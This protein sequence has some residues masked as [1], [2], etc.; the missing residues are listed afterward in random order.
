M[1]FETEENFFFKCLIYF[2][3]WQSVYLSWKN[4]TVHFS[5]YDFSDCCKEQNHL[6]ISHLL[7]STAI[8]KAVLHSV[9]SVD[10]HL[11]PF[12]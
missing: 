9:C 4:L 6:P 1:S 12:Y 8:G 7:I 11:I 3:Q 2:T 5:L 10:S